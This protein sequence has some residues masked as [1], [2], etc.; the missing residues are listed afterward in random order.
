MLLFLS[1]MCRLVFLRALQDG[2]KSV[3]STSI[4]CYFQYCII[5]GCIIAE[6]QSVTEHRSVAGYRE[7]SIDH[8]RPF[9]QLVVT[10]Q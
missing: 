10:S 3:L 6:R 5:Q 2:F 9:G 8:C 7:F 4:I 1:K